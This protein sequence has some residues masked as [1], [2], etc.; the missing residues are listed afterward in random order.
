MRSAILGECVPINRIVILDQENTLATIPPL[1]D[2]VRVVR[3]DDPGEASHAASIAI[4][5]VIGKVSP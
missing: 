4:N 5:G 1:R 3:N 2:V